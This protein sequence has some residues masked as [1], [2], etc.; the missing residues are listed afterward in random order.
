MCFRIITLFLAFYAS[1]GPL[2][3]IKSVISC[4]RRRAA[5]TAPLKIEIIEPETR[6]RSFC[7]IVRKMLDCNKRPIWIINDKPIPGHLHY[8][9]EVLMD[10]QQT[11]SFFLT[12]AESESRLKLHREVHIYDSNGQK[13]QKTWKDEEA[14]RLI[15]RD[16]PF[17]R[18]QLREHY[19]S[20]DLEKLV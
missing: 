5:P 8:F 12:D 13:I 16:M 11:A 9:L 3:F 18:E 10:N 6:P 14:E 1:A 15:Q 7:G 20:A 19:L 17:L 4:K 2:S